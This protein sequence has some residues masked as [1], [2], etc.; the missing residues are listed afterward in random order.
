MIFYFYILKTK[1]D[2]KNDNATCSDEYVNKN[3]QYVI[4]NIL[5][6]TTQ[7]W[8]VANCDDC[9]NGSFSDGN[10]NFSSHTLEIKAMHDNYSQCTSMFKDPTIIC[11][12]CE[13]IYLDL[14]AKFDHEKKVREGKICFDLEDIVSWDFNTSIPKIVNLFQ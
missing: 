2:V 8:D 10:Q 11:H 1:N 9:Y 14:N 13:K 7:I 6:T 3:Q 5:K 4:T 12:N